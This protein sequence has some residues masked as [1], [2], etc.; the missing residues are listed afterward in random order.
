MYFEN[1]DLD[2]IVTPVITGEFDRLLKQ[3]NYPNDKR[4]AIVAGFTEGFYIGYQG[5][6][7]VQIK[8]PNLKFRVGNTCILWNKVMKEGKFKRFVGPFESINNFIQSPIGLVDKDNGHDMRLIF[9]LSYQRTNKKVL[10]NANTP[11]ELCTV[12]YQ[13]FGQAIR[14][15]LDFAR[16]KTF[17]FVKSDALS[18]FHNLGLNRKLWPWLVMKARS[19]LNDK[20]YFLLIN[21]CHLAAP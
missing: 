15:C 1:F 7:N 21:A 11:P 9:H 19:P 3:T 6:R 16:H 18:A 14:L 4:H 20:W 12:K 2:N 10:V 17:Y 8:S 13:D 5:E